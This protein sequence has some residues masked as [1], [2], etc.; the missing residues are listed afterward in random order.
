MTTNKY[1]VTGQCLGQCDDS[2]VAAWRWQ[3]QRHIPMAT[4]SAI[5]VAAAT[6][7]T[8]HQRPMTAS[9]QHV[10]YIKAM[11]TAETMVSNGSRRAKQLFCVS[12]RPRYGLPDTSARIILRQR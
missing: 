12:M 7:T 5:A 4:A 3:Q 6:A 2:L 11:H 10:V 9:S 8:H 1:L